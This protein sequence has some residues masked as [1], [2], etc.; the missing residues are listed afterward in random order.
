MPCPPRPALLITK[1][2]KGK[3]FRHWQAL[4]K[5]LQEVV[6]SVVEND[7]LSASAALGGRVNGS[8]NGGQVIGMRVNSGLGWRDSLPWLNLY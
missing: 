7:G 1:L 3:G 5:S 6:G 2:Y 8:T 4:M